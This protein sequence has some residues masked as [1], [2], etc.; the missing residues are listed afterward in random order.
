VFRIVFGAVVLLSVGRLFAYGWVDSLYAGPERHFAYPG[1]SWVPVLSPVAMMVQLCVVGLA[2]LAV[3]V[4][5]HH[6]VAAIVC[7][8]GFSWM[9]FVEASVYLNHYWFVTLAGLLVVVLPVADTWSLDARCAAAAGGA[10]AVGGAGGARAGLVPVGAVWLVRAQV[11]V[12]YVLA[13]VAKLH[14]DWLVHGAPLSLWLPARADLPLVGGLLAAP[15]AA[16]ALSWAGA[17]FDCTVVAFLLWRPTRLWAWLAVVAFHVSTWILFPIIGVFPWLMIGASTVFFDPD[18]PGRLLARVR[19]G[20]TSARPAATVLLPTRPARPVRTVAL[21][22]AG[23]WLALQVLVPLRFVL[24]PGDHRW[25][26][27]AYRFGWNVLAAEKSGDVVFRVTDTTTGT[28]SRTDAS[29]LYTTQ[30]WRTMVNEPELIRQAAHAVAEDA[31]ARAG[32]DVDDVEVRVDAYVSFNGRAPERLID[33]SVDLA[34]EPWRLGHQ[35]W[36]LPAPTTDPPT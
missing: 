21:V 11:G 12:V 34:A 4:G 16:V 27:E 36:I 13:G 29:G 14:G 28:T 6:R 19:G 30:Q 31:A 18:W 10:G 33:P 20:R 32:V 22:A 23:F 3:V 15:S 35:R 9:E 26:G 17:L 7:W 8:L 24:Y 25:T 1:M 2:A 5:F